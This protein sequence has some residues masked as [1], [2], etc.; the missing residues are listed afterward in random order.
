MAGSPASTPQPITPPEQT[1]E[2][3]PRPEMKLDWMRADTEWGVRVEPEPAWMQLGDLNVGSY[4][5]IPDH[6][7]DDTM[8]PRGVEAYVGAA[9][10]GYAVFVKHEGWSDN[11]AALYEEAIQRRWKPATNIAQ[12]SIPARPAEVE[13]ALAQVLTHLAE[14]AWVQS[15]TYGEWFKDVSYGY[16]EAKLF[17]ATVVFWLARHAEAFR[18]HAMLNGGRMGEQSPPNLHRSILGARNFTDSFTEVLLGT[19]VASAAHPAEAKLF[20]LARQD[21]VRTL[22]YGRGRLRN[23]I[24]ATPERIPELHGY[25]IRAEIAVTQDMRDTIAS[26]P[27]SIV[28]GGDVEVIATGAERLQ[29]LRRAQAEAYLRR[30]AGAGLERREQQWSHFALATAQITRDEYAPTRA[31]KGK[32]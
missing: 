13:R 7:P 1:P 21:R 10:M 27:L 30:L 25:L 20:T 19:L 32:R 2:V 4:G 22:A 8:R 18:K 23:A 26:E 12:A 16:H 24:D 6:W 17:L 14:Q 9:G 15:V 5:E 3:L 31:Q 28:L 29:N 11:A